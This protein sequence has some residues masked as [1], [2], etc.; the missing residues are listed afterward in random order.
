MGYSVAVENG[1][2]RASGIA[3]KL[4]SIG[5]SW[6]DQFEISTL[7]REDFEFVAPKTA[8]YDVRQVNNQSSAATPRGH[9]FPAAVMAIA[10]GLDKHGLDSEDPIPYCHLDIGGASVLPPFD[11]VVTGQPVTALTAF[12]IEA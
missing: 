5:E 9:Q 1:P 6:G 7:R 3:R 4:Q 10:S 8:E 11:G 12:V 2:S